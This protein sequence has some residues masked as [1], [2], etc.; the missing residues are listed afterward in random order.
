MRRSQK[1]IQSTPWL[2]VAIF[3]LLM[4]ASSCGA[5]D[6][7]LSTINAEVF[8]GSC[9]FESCHGGPSPESDLD[10]SSV[11]AAYATLIDVPGEAADVVRVVPGDPD[12]SLLYQLLLTEVEDARKM[13]VGAQLP[14]NELEA[15]RQ[16]IEDGA[17]NN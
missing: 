3:P 6:P 10:L 7:T 15:I 13:P 2:P 11:E 5:L 14:D 16:W 9:A 12:N 1:L 4:A 17:E 8:E